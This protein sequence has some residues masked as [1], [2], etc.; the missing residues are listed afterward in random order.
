MT[1]KE[2]RK[3]KIKKKHLTG[4]TD[5]QK[6]PERTA[7]FWPKFPCHCR[8]RNVVKLY[9]NGNAMVPLAPVQTYPDSFESTNFSLRIQKF[10]RPHVS[11]FK[12]NLPVHTY[13]D[14]LS[15][16]QLIGKRSS[17]LAK[18]YRQ[19]SSVN[20]SLRKLSHQAL[21]RSFNFFTASNPSVLF[22]KKLPNVKLQ[23]GII[24]VYSNHS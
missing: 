23:F 4:L 20:V 1:A 2:T 8:T 3:L 14:S 9:W 22:G 17:A 15:V 16:R 6:T 18:F 10:P 5:K 12:S 19:Y 13:P 11:V 21:F 24:E 7:H